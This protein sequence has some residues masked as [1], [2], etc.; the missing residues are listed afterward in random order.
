MYQR[1]F[2]G[3]AIIVTAPFVPRWYFLRL[4]SQPHLDRLFERGVGVV[5]IVKH[6]QQ[7]IIWNVRQGA[8]P[9]FA[10]RH[11]HGVNRFPQARNGWWCC[12]SRTTVTWEVSQLGG[13]RGRLVRLMKVEC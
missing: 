10:K 3:L 1:C 11:L 6:P 4:D 9:V 13:G 12:A 2:P 7:L 5:A 8:P